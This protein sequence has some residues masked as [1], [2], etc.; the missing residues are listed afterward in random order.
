[1]PP[2]LVDQTAGLFIA[3]PFFHRLSG[4]RLETASA[5]LGP[6]R[7][8]LLHE[9]P[10]GLLRN[11]VKEMNLVHVECQAVLRHHAR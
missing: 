11:R 1:M 7:S 8:G 10:D 6:P 4:P 2:S 5:T 9:P 3:S